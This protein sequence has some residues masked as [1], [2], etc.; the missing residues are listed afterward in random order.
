MIG[1]S[2]FIYYFH[3][4]RIVYENGYFPEV[5][6]QEKIDLQSISK[7]DFYREY[8]WVVLSSGMSEKV[9]KKVF[10]R[11]SL[12]FNNWKNPNYI[13]RHQKKK[14]VQALSIFNNRPKISALFE[15]ARRLCR[16]TCSNIINSIQKVGTGYLMKFKFMG[17]A[18]SL[19]LAKNLGVN[20]A[21]PDRHLV[22]IA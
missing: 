17:P 12:V 22:R 20:T 21:K 13:V 7:S 19:H 8:A 2:H 16:I 11:I 4:K 15:M 1:E 5:H 14:Y 18:T 3:A 6:F 10:Q 9:V